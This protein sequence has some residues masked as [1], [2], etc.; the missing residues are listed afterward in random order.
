MVQCLS[1]SWHNVIGSTSITVL[2]AFCDT[3]ESLWDSDEEHVEFAKYY[4]ED[5]CFLY[6][7]SEHNDK[8]VCDPCDPKHS[9]FI[10][11]IITY[12]FSEMEGALS[13]PLCPPDI[14]CSPH[15][16]WRFCK[17]SWSPWQT[18]DHGSGWVRLGHCHSTYCVFC[19]QCCW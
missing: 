11:L 6:Q 1:D 17:D 2:L 16:Y 4:L 18:H 3:Q 13:Q 15:G 12:Y 9:L 14:C 10:C 7:V 19:L 5:L 8:K